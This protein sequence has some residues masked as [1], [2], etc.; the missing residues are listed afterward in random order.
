MLIRSHCQ[1]PIQPRTAG[2]LT[3]AL[4]TMRQRRVGQEHPGCPAL[5]DQS[6]YRVWIREVR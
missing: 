3:A 4:P 5:E 2:H 6:A 1:R